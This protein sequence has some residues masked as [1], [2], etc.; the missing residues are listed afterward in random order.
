MKRLLLHFV[1]LFA[2]VLS[3]KAQN[4]TGTT[5][6][7]WQASGL[8]VQFVNTSNPL[9]GFTYRWTFGDG[10]A[11]ELVSPSHLYL[12]P[13]SY[14]VCLRKR[15][16]NNVTVDST[17]KTITLTA[18]IC[19][20]DFRDSAINAMTKKF[21]PIF[22]DPGANP[23]PPVLQWSFGDGTGSSDFSPT[24]QY[25]QAGA[26]T[27]CLTVQFSIGCTAQV[28]RTILIGATTVCQ[29]DFRDSTIGTFTK[30]FFPVTPGGTN[31]ADTGIHYTW[32]FGDGSTSTDRS[33][34]HQ[35]AQ[36][37]QYNVCVRAVF[38]NGCVAEKCRVII[39]EAVCEVNFRD[40]LVGPLTEHFIPVLPAGTNSVIINWSFGDGTSSTQ[41]DPTHQYAQPGT[42]NVCLRVQYPNGCVAYKC[43][44]ITIPPVVTCVTD[45]IDTLIG[46]GT[47]HFWAL[48]T[49]N[50]VTS[51]QWNF[52]DGT[53]ANTADPTHHFNQPG[54]Y[55]VCLKVTFANGCIAYKCKDIIIPPN[56][57]NCEVGFI[58]SAISGYTIKFIP[59]TMQQ[60]FVASYLWN[61]GDGSTST[62]PVPVHTYNTSGTYNVCLSVRYT[63]PGSTVLAC[64]ARSCRVVVVRG[65]ACGVIINDSLAQGPLNVQ[66]W[67]ILTRNDVVSLLWNFGDG[68]TSTV[69][70]P[71]HHYQHGGRYRVCLNVRYQYDNCEANACEDVMLA[72]EP[73]RDSFR[74]EPNYG[75]NNTG[76]TYQFFNIVNRNDAI[77]YQWSFGD[78]TSSMLPNPVKNYL[79]PGNYN[80]CLRVTFANGCVAYFC[81]VVS[82]VR[83]CKVE[84]QDSLISTRKYKF[85]V[86]SSRPGTSTY[87]W[88]F[89]DGS[90]SNAAAPV[91]EF[92]QNGNYHVCV[93]VVFADGCVA[94]DCDDLTVFRMASSDGITVNSYPSP[95]S[96]QV[97]FRLENTNTSNAS[98]V[99][100]IYT[101]SGSFVKRET[102]TGN[103]NFSVNISELR[104]GSYIAEI[105]LRDRTL[106]KNFIKM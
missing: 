96:D 38:P 7:T 34:V 64:E 4:T 67:S 81:K 50:A 78:G 63:L 22:S 35:Y 71:L 27:V 65:A 80:V 6:F 57:A 89:G 42:Y 60:Y 11:S 101:A 53:G 77:I 20:A 92:L 94:E 10:T 79:Q 66:F 17:C 90:T 91:H 75:P 48:A 84:I 54:T 9:S 58:D 68:T 30:K 1:M 43:R 56:T 13:G 83:T 25:A 82:I 15:T 70:N 28:C 31:I 95:A 33:P 41:F 14:T 5:D 97:S 12:Q 8:N 45:F 23:L 99:I 21:F 32:N 98:A 18:P 104:Q 62:S 16:S 40:S 2:S 24:H 74:V 39:V 100:S 47:Y 69:R 49:S 88:N 72:E 52:G 61:F 44:L 37:G 46:P 86:R 87:Q 3:L 105:T 76:L 55:H 85:S 36:A 103:N 29:I 102:V 19:H 93:R 73:C 51:Y 59:R 26:Y 106:R